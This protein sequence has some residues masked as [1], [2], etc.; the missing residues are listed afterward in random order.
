MSSPWKFL[1]RLISPRREQ[2]R[3]NGATEKATKSGPSQIADP[4][5]TIAEESLNS[6]GRPTSDAT[7]H[8]R[9]A[10]IFTEPVPSEEAKNDRK[11]KVEIEDAGVVQAAHPALSG[12]T[13]TDIIAALR[14][15][16]VQAVE[17]APRKQRS[18][19]KKALAVPNTPQAIR[20]N[21]TANEIN[22]DEEIRL[23]RGQ[24]ARRLKLQNE[25]LRKMLERFER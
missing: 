25:Q 17:V 24:L 11:D 10:S 4:T 15:V 9:S 6:E 20:V 14:A 13:G 19:G 21:D 7:H 2:G 3:E 23:L 12:E 5:E 22:L 1:V 18:R 16:D 8:D